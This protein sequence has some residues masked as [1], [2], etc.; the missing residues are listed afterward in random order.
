LAT[1]SSRWSS[2]RT[3]SIP[4]I[5]ALRRR[6]V[7]ALLD[8]VQ[9]DAALAQLSA[10]GHQVQDRAA[11]AVQPRDL[12]RVALAQDAQDDVELRA[13]GFAPLAWST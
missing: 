3:D 6:G 11:E 7:D 10:K 5:A 12:Q 13:A 9:A 1:I 2:A 4:N 8:D